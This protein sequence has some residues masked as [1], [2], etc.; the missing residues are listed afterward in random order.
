M[1]A[2]CRPGRPGDLFL[3]IGT[4]AQAFKW[5]NQLKVTETSFNYIVQSP[6]PKVAPQKRLAYFLKFLESPDELVSSDA[7]A[8]FSSASYAD[9]ITIRD[10]MPVEKVRKWALSKET[11]P[12][13]LSLYGLMLGL[14]GNDDDARAL[15][16]RINEKTEDFRLGVDGLISGYLLLSGPEGLDF[17]DESKLKNKSIPFSETYAAMQALRFIW[18]DGE[19]V[20]EKDRLLASM[21]L[22][23]D[24]PGLADLVIG[25]LA[26]WKDWSVQEQLMGL[27]DVDEYDIP[28]VKRAIVRYML[29]CSKDVPKKEQPQKA[30]KIVAKLPEHARAAK[31]H[32]ATLRKNDPKTVKDAERFFFLN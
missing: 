31:K 9:V 11:S 16:A 5:S 24:Q 21:R 2:R 13:R 8:E 15:K 23:L 14:C 6:S 29:T 30:E 19:G 10:K 25:D 27:Y 20:I 18:T 26:R 3:L 1:L 22:L 7:Y 28:C 12:T 4:Q 32:L 17:I